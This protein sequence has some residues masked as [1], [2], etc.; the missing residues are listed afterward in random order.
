MG[1]RWPGARG[2]RLGRALRSA[3]SRTRPQVQILA[4]PLINIKFCS[5]SGLSFSVC[6][7]E[8]VITFVSYTYRTVYTGC[9]C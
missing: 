5:F 9:A 6:E 4:S 7:M 2:F 1:L 8:L 3:I